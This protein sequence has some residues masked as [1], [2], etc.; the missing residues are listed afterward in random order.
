[1]PDYK[2][3][4]KNFLTNVI[5][6]VDYPTIDTLTRP[7]EPDKFRDKISQKFKNM[8][9]IQGGLVDFELKDTNMEIRETRRKYA[10]EFSN[11]E[12]TTTIFLDSDFMKIECTKF[13]N[14]DEF[15]KDIEMIFSAFQDTYP[16]KKAN[17]TELRYINQIRIDTGNPL[18]WSGLIKNSLFSVAKDFIRD[19]SNLLR[20]L[21]YFE[22]RESEYHLKFTFG[23]FNSEYPNPIARKEFV[24]DYDCYWNEEIEA[25]TIL[26]KIKVFNE[27]ITYWFEQ[28]IDDGLRT[29]MEVI[30]DGNGQ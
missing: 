24:L 13:T 14:F 16:I 2:T 10:W 19:K 9:A 23:L 25:T 11:V 15:L 5:V 8:R 12:K 27:K 30:T 28:S 1:M 29:I 7:N 4:R 26:D 21:Q 3:Y 17:R 22:I 18:D 6:R 20:N